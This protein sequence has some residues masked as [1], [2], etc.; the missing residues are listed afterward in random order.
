MLQA[1]LGADSPL[2]F[3]PISIPSDV[4]REIARSFVT[5]ARILT[6]VATGN[7]GRSSV[8]L[9]SVMNF[10]ERWTPPPPNAGQMP[11]LGIFHYYRVE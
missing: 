1:Y 10:H 8:R 5:A 7:V 9:R 3:Q 4:R 11:G 6:I 2:M